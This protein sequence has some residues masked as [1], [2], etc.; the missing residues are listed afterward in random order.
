MDQETLDLLEFLQLLGIV[1]TFAHSPLGKAEIRDV[2]PGLGEDELQARLARVAEAIRFTSAGTRP[3][4]THIEDPA[5]SLSRLGVSGEVL[6][7]NEILQLLS[8]L[9]TFD[10][11]QKSLSPAEWPG[12][13]ALVASIPP[14]DSDI[15]EIERVIDPS[16]EIRESA[17]PELA[18]ARREQGRYRERVQ[19]HLRRYFAGQTAKYLVDDPYVTLRNGRYVIPVR[20]EHQRD[21]AGVVH[22]SS[23]SGAT[24]FVEPFPVVQLNNQY[25]YYQEREQEIIFRILRRL[26]DRL[27]TGVP[28]FHEAAA[29][30]GALDAVLACALFA[31]RYRA[32]V[33]RVAANYSLRLE[34]ARHPL[35][36][37]RIGPD[38]VVPISVSLTEDKSVLIIS[39]PN[40]GGKTVALKTIGLLSLMASAGLPIPAQDGEMPRFET[41]LA[42]IG[43]HQS[44]EQQLS[45]FSA[46]ILRLKRMLELLATPALILLDEVGAG[47]DPAH[48]AVLGISVVDV[49]RRRRGLVVATT[50]HSAIKQFAAATP[51]VQNASVELD[52]KTLTPTYQLRTGVAGGSSGLEIASM[53]GLPQEI[54]Q[55]ARSLLSE[56]DVQAERYLV[57]LR[58]ELGRLEDERDGLR[59]EREN[60]KA[61]A[62]RLREE[63]ERKERERQEAV[64]ESLGRWAE[65]FHHEGEHFVKGIKDRFEAA[66]LRKE[67]KQRQA[68]LKEAFRRK[69]TSE[70]RTRGGSGQN[71]DALVPDSLKVGDPVYHAFFRKQGKVVSLSGGSAVVEIDGKRVSASVDQLEM[72][73]DQPQA[74]AKRQLPPNVT[75]DAVEEAESELNLIGQTVDDALALADKFL[76]RAFMASLQQ[77]RIIHGFGTGRLKAALSSFLQQHPHVAKHQVEGG[78]TVV[79]IKQ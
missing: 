32:V 42:S 45:T 21:V 52:E 67:I 36:M 53:L 12:L 60:L 1:E 23:S 49:F 59:Q 55:Q 68:A 2:R 47:T 50:H 31:A 30:L 35:L 40:A 7:P 29:A 41:I 15:T 48:G 44:L 58:H 10:Q 71:Q 25:L 39:G 77:V 22:G 9:K 76:D 43:D 18:Q 16:G 74:P 14:V 34:A 24:L 56:Q 64:E 72:P 27:K 8:L 63:H 33:P 4:F 62:V 13:A 38:K 3:D 20:L 46:H 78:A 26:A 75:L 70:T 5:E 6:E 61:E 65:E 69:I 57:E 11:L 37:Q 54:V 51:G 79:S 19:E 17:D 73:A 28:T 66:R